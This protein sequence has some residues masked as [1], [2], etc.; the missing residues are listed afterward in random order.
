MISYLAAMGASA[1]GWRVGI[2]LGPL[3]AI[4]VSTIAAA[5]ALYTTRRILHDHLD[6]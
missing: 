4:L 1:V 6:L 3:T 5:A 2:A